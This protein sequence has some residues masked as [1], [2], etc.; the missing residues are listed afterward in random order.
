MTNANQ[1]EEKNDVIT[2][3]F[4]VPG[5]FYEEIKFVAERDGN[6]INGMMMILAR[7]GLKLYTKVYNSEFTVKIDMQ[8]LY[9]KK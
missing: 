4:R 6:T 7:M 8:D 9:E 1:T 3:T 5:E 2:T